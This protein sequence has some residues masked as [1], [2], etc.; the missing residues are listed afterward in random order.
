[1][2]ELPHGLKLLDLGIGMSAAL[3]AKQLVELGI[4]AQRI[5][6]PESDPFYE[7][8]PAFFEENMVYTYYPFSTSP[9]ICL[10]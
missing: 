5:E 1:M 10:R 6:P 2:S 9:I 7:M 8:L 3:V 4:S